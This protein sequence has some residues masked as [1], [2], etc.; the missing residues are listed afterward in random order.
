MSI[1][2]IAYIA[3]SAATAICALA[4]SWYWYLSSKP[5]PAVGDPPD[6]SVSDNPEFRILNTETD[7]YAVQSA[8][9]V[10]SRLNKAAAIWS[11]IAALFGAAAAILGTV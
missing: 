2:R 5:T 4:A 8:L 6:V 3:C 10:A 7:I 9:T 1:V 11:A